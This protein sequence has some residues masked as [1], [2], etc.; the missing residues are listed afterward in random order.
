MATSPAYTTQPV[1]TPQTEVLPTSGEQAPLPPA[2]S[3][4]IEAGNVV[5]SPNTQDQVP[6]YL[7]TIQDA[8]YGGTPGANYNA[9]PF[10]PDSDGA[11]LQS[12][13][14]PGDRP[15]LV[16]MVGLYE[17]VRNEKGLGDIEKALTDLEAQ[18]MEAEARL[19]GRSQTERGKA[20]VN[21]GVIE[22]RIGQVERQERENIDFINRQISTKSFQLQIGNDLVKTIMD[23]TST[24]YNNAVQ[25]YNSR[26]AENIQ[27]Y[28]MV[29]SKRRFDENLIFQKEQAVE[30]KRQF[31]V[32]FA[33]QQKRA[34]ENMARANLQIYMDLVTKGSV[35]W[36]SLSESQKGMINKLEVQSGLPVGFMSSMTIPAGANIKNISTRVDASGTQWTDILMLN[37]D[38]TF[39]VKSE[40]MG[41]TYQTKSAASSSSKDKAYTTT[42]YNG[43]LSILR[44]LDSSKSLTLSTQNIADA[45][46]NARTKYGMDDSKA[47]D[48]IWDAI[49]G[50]G[51]TYD[52]V[53]NVGTKVGQSA[54]AIAK[55]ISS[56]A[57]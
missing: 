26:L 20:G 39:T 16:S 45:V 57:W 32:Q 2:P 7:Q 30:E 27:M 12:Q 36:G 46:K 47:R 40:K 25:D 4:A 1:T 31:E 14:S 51:Y 18:R 11:N 37:N 24:D 53:K 23:L 3:N 41:S 43:A 34:D 48:L 50:A 49:E 42:Q 38:G 8:I 55:K 44:S 33:E 5:P 35:A 15:G 9:T 21:L 52:P 29:E 10:A 28:E 56:G 6:A 17:Q 54:S 13:L 19:R 22:G